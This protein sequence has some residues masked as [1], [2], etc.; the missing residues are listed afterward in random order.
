VVVGSE[1]PP[2]RFLLGLAACRRTPLQNLSQQNTNTT[3]ATD[4]TE[5]PAKRA[6]L[7]EDSDSDGEVGGVSLSIN[8]EYAKR[9]EY[10]EKR[11]EKEKRMVSGHILYIIGTEAI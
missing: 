2:L 7:L 1:N 9:Y 3:M 8:K 5:R 4:G 11:K 10:N 6:K